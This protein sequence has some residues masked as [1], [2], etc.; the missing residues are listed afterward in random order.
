MQVLKV[1]FRLRDWGVSRQRYWGCP[2]P[3]I[4]CDKCGQVPVPEEQLPVVLPTDVVPDGSGNPLNKMPEFYR[5]QLAQA[6]VAMHVVK[7]IPWIP[8]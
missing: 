3:M 2:I 4:N 6:V 7:P 5:N 1:Q 8:L